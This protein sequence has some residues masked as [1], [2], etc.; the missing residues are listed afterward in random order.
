MRGTRRRESADGGDK[1]GVWLW[2]SGR[3]RGS[4]GELEL[5]EEE[6]IGVF[7]LL[8]NAFVAFLPCS[9]G[10]SPGSHF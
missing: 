6:Q 3:K 5:G 10:E 4:E 9:A 7:H 2:S 8:F 1:L